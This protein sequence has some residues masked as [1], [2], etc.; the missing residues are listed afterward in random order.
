MSNN[1]QEPAYF[2]ISFYPSDIARDYDVNELEFGKWL[3]EQELEDVLYSICMGI[4]LHKFAIRNEK[5]FSCEG[6]KA[7][8]LRLVKD[9]E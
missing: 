9:D 8:H 1:P 5:P 4:V 3:Q 6:T 7:A 2:E